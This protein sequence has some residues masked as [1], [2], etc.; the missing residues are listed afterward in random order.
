MRE[1]VRSWAIWW[2]LCAALWL[3]LV[4]RIHADELLTGAG[5]AAGGATVAV[6][7]R[8]ERL[9]ILRPPPRW[10]RGVLRPVAG[11]VADL[12]PLV[13]VLVTRGLL[14]RD[15]AGPLIELPYPGADDPAHRTLTATLGSLAPNT[16]VVDVDEE[17]RILVAHQLRPTGDAAR[18]AL[19][20]GADGP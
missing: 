17:R 10:T 16:I 9:T 7:V 2:A 5:V 18:D 1:H 15:D 6:L 13:R 19:P 8:R 3:L 4:D 11:M 20:L 12:V 14:R